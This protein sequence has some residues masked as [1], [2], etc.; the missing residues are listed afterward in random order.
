[1]IPKDKI[2]HLVFGSGITTVCA[3]AIIF[4]W[5]PVLHPEVTLIS[6]VIG[7]LAG[8]GKELVWD[9]W[10]KKGTPEFADAY[11]TIWVS[12]TTAILIY[13]AYIVYLNITL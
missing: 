4:I 2:K 5:S 13:M 7:S 10:L 8:I 3:F 6:G 11:A 9:K 12:L 1:M